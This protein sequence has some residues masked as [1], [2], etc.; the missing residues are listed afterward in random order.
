[1]HVDPLAQVTEPLQFKPPHW[2]YNG[3]VPPA[4]LVEEAEVVLEVEVEVFV[5][6]EVVA[7]APAPAPLP[8]KSGV[9]GVAPGK[10]VV[11]IV[12]IAIDTEI[13]SPD[14][15]SLGIVGPF[16][17]VGALDTVVVLV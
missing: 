11:G 5:A 16:H 17:P 14:C 7:L 2:P 4:A 13:P 1:V 3:T 10:N 6:D 12:G 15:S 9:S 8:F